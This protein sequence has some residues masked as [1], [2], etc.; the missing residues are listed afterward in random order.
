MDRT[1]E[2]K[3]QEEEK[4]RLRDL[5]E[6]FLYV[7]IV[8]LLSIV[9]VT[10]VGQRTIVDGNS[11][12]PTLQNGDNLIV[13]KISYKFKSPARFDI[14]VF[15]YEYKEN[16][17]Y[18]KRVIG[19]PGE[20]VQIDFDGNI[21]INGQV[22]SEDYGL[23]TIENPG[24]FAEPVTLG[25]DEYFVLGDNRN[26]SEDSRFSDVGLIKRKNIIGKAWVRIYPFN[27]IHLLNKA[28]HGE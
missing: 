3:E 28:Y 22:L 4:F 5:I 1:E 12:N 25:D 8:I 20:T 21:Y 9:I 6:I 18:I 14:I 17:N 11:M 23:E 2:K 7:G 10:F 24:N 16:T 27:R 19:L 15:P 13:D 26:H